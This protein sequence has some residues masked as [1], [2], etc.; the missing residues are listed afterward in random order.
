MPHHPADRANHAR[1]LIGGGIIGHNDLKPR[2][3]TFQ[4]TGQTQHR[5]EQIVI[6]R[7]DDA[8][9]GLPAGT[10]RIR[11]TRSAQSWLSAKPSR[12]RH[13]SISEHRYQ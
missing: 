3:A 12:P 2:P 6:H 5:I 4:N 1:R 13:R 8:D 11:A 10:P 9:L 7:H